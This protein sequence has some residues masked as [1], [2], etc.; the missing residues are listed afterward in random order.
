MS[1]HSLLLP[2]SPLTPNIRPILTAISLLD[3][4]DRLRQHQPTRLSPSAA[5]KD[6]TVGV[7]STTATASS[8]V[9]TGSAAL[10]EAMVLAEQA[11][12]AASLVSALRS[13]A[14]RARH[15]NPRLSVAREV[16]G[17]RTATTVMVT[18]VEAIMVGTAGTA[19]PMI[20]TVHPARLPPGAGMEPNLPMGLALGALGPAPGLTGA[21][22]ARSEV[23]LLRTAIISPLLSHLPSLCPQTR[24]LLPTP[25]R[26]RT[27]RGS[28]GTLVSLST[29]VVG[30]L[31]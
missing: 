28:M 26:R 13:L 15:P 14:G 19:T 10:V 12:E 7:V 23:H 31:A 2:S 24:M 20:P 29:L 8:R 9:T 1:N 4:V 22:V 21:R 5:L 17:I 16:L 3:L 30:S 27:S 25:A 11:L 18:M 6:R